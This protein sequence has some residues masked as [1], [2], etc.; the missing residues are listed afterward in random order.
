MICALAA[1]PCR[2]STVLARPTPPTRL[3]GPPSGSCDSKASK[4]PTGP[5]A[6]W[7]IGHLLLW[8][9]L[10]A[11]RCQFTC[12]GACHLIFIS[13]GP[14][15]R[16]VSH[17][18]LGRAG[19]RSPAAKLTKSKVKRSSPPVDRLA[20]Q[21]GATD[22][23]GRAA[24]SGSLQG[25]GR[26][27]LNLRPVRTSNRWF[28]QSHLQSTTD[29]DDENR[30]LLHPPE[31]LTARYLAASAGSG[32]NSSGRP[33]AGE[34]QVATRARERQRVGESCSRRSAGPSESLCVMIIAAI[35]ILIAAND[36]LLGAKCRSLGGGELGQQVVELLVPAEQ[37]AGTHQ[38]SVQFPAANPTDMLLA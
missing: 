6:E 37:P 36:R 20:D 10:R 4:L 8:G 16:P 11:S 28:P 33:V 15:T 32:G 34:Q 12:Q 9:S 30:S 21:I 29:A 14:A 7:P 2:W 19:N 27:E 35:L 38:A 13:A 24:T 17:L 25:G 26:A 23:P 22:R 31:T 3:E 18:G 1:K 5:L